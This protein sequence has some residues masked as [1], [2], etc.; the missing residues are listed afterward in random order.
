MKTKQSLWVISIAFIILLA[1]Q[2]LTPAV[3]SEPTSRPPTAPAPSAT[4]TPELVTEKSLAGLLVSSPAL[5]S[6][7]EFG[8][9]SYGLGIVNEDGELVRI[10]DPAQ[11]D[12]YSPSGKKIVY[13]H[14]YSQ[15]LTRYA[16]HLK[17]YHA[18]TGQTVEVE[19]G[20]EGVKE[21]ITWLDSE[22]DKFIYFNN[23]GALLFEAYGY[24]EGQEILMADSSTGEVSLLLEDVFQFEVSPDQT[25][26]AFTNGEQLKLQT[27]NMEYGAGCFHP[28]LYNIAQAASSAFDLSSLSEEPV[29]AGY[30]MWA[31]DGKRIAWIGYFE[32]D[33]FRPIVF[34]VGTGKGKFYDEIPAHGGGQFPG[35]WGINPSPG[36]IDERTFWTPNYEVDTET[37]T[38]STS[39]ENPWGEVIYSSEPEP[40]THPDGKLNVKLAEGVIEVTYTN[41]N[42][43]ASYALD[44]LYKGSKGPISFA[45]T[46]YY[47]TFLPD[48]SPYAPPAGVVSDIP[49]VDLNSTPAPPFSCSNA[50]TTRLQVGDSARISFTDGTS[51]LLRSAPEAGD[52]VVDKLPEGTELEITGGPVCY[53]RPGRSDAYVYWEVLVP[54]R[55][56]RTGWVAEGDLDSYYVEPWP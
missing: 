22:P 24:F 16:Y 3:T 2:P 8:I 51:T 50:P 31:P 45:D 14:G 1:C 56:N 36:W 23:Y 32:D 19:D 49:D 20:L 21:V 11:F 7:Q 5:G 4:P 48:W 17:V 28:Q 33:T 54:S 47:P 38:T 6:L 37:D 30:P 15:G 26:I 41:G 44:D 43:L 55:S 34:D 35:G 39:R 12:S 10:A 18:D 46:E 52:N 40:T 27:D 9:Q 42:I 25:L 29:C 53:P 13:Q